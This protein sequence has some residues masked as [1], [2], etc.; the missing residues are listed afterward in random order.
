[1]AALVHLKTSD[2]EKKMIED[3]SGRYLESQKNRYALRQSEKKDTKQSP[4]DQIL[5]YPWQSPAST[6]CLLKTALHFLSS[7]SIISGI[8]DNRFCQ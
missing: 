7:F 3:W 6:V 4:R 1:M 2:E 5:S 8:S